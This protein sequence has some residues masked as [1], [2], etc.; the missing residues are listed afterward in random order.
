MQ[1]LFP[2]FRRIFGNTNSGNLVTFFTNPDWSE[3]YIV[4]NEKQG[5][6]LIL[7]KLKHPDPEILKKF[8]RINP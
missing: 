3:R 5:S 7:E 6:P 4:L 1:P 8:P 2:L